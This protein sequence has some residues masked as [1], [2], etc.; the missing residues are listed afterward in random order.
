MRFAR[1]IAFITLASLRIPSTYAADREELVDMVFVG[2]IMLDDLPGE[3]VAR[4]VDPF[5]EFAEIFRSA[6]I[7]IGNLECVVATTGEPEDKPYTFRAHPRCIPLLNRYFTAVTIANNHSGDFGKLA[8]VQQCELFE[9]A[10]LPYFG[11]G[12]N[13]PAAHKPLVIERKGIRVALLGYNEFQ[14]RRFEAGPMTAGIAWS[15]DERVVSDIKAAREQSKADLVIPFMHWGWEN[16]PVNER[17]QQ[18]ART[19]IDAGAD[20]VVGAHPHV[21]QAIE[22]YHGKLIAYSLG[23]FVFDDFDK[24]EQLTA[25]VLQ[26]RVNRQGLQEW[27]T[28]VA[29]IDKQGIPHL[30]DDARSPHGMAG[31][32]TIEGYDPPYPRAGFKDE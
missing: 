25:W 24:D 11:G 30:D 2:D 19:M 32:L 12:R 15:V 3:A 16:E 21:R 31:S 8:L 14:P 20:I 13:L 5:A 29:R 7:T 18:L 4:G 9:K 17:Q 6:D 28:H 27:K 10:E 1:L 23:N 26:F 22:Y